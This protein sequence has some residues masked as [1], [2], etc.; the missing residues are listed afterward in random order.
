MNTTAQSKSQSKKYVHSI[1]NRQCGSR[2]HSTNNSLSSVIALLAID[3]N[4]NMIDNN[5]NPCNEF[6]CIKKNN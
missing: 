2:Y 6:L 3:N 4:E 5:T 1:F